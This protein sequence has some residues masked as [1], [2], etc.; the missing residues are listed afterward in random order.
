M[1][2]HFWVISL[3]VKFL[4]VLS[5][6]FEL[7]NPFLG[8]LV[9]VF[10]SHLENFLCSLFLEAPVVGSNFLES[11]IHACLVS[12]YLLYFSLFLQQSEKRPCILVWV[13]VHYK[14]D[15]WLTSIQ[16]LLLLFIV[17]IIWHNFRITCYQY[18]VSLD[19]RSCHEFSQPNTPFLF[20]SHKGDNLDSHFVHSCSLFYLFI[21]FLTRV[22]VLLY[23]FR[24]CCTYPITSVL[25][26]IFIC[27]F[28]CVFKFYLF[29]D[30]DWVT[31]PSHI[32]QYQIFPIRNISLSSVELF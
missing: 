8:F 2:H 27:L 15:C 1:S 14:I 6:Y 5:K 16:K 22:T 20:F 17:C 28:F 30:Y 29:T 13:S 7:V 26:L 4:K 21:I 3:H 23:D 25:L 9:T 31:F 11:F 32:L 10:G 19:F 24:V 12:L 18:I